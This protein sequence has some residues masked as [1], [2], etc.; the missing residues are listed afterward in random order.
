M[1]RANKR[2]LS[3]L[4]CLLQKLLQLRI[5]KASR[6][7]HGRLN[8]LTRKQPTIKFKFKYSR[9]TLKCLSSLKTTKGFNLRK[10]EGCKQMKQTVNQAQTQS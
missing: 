1:R 2:N 4:L 5:R 7:K 8:Q 9:L 3:Q 10:K 6:V